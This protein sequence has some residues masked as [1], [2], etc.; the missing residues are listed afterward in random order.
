MKHTCGPTILI[1]R[2]SCCCR[3]RDYGAEAR[4]DGA[5]CCVC[6]GHCVVSISC[7]LLNDDPLTRCAC[8][9][10]RCCGHASTGTDF[11][12]VQITSCFVDAQAVLQMGWKDSGQTVANEVAGIADGVDLSGVAFDWG[13]CVCL[14]LMI[15]DSVEVAVRLHLPTAHTR[16]EPEG[17]SEDLCHLPLKGSPNVNTDCTLS[18]YVELPTAC[19]TVSICTPRFLSNKTCIMSHS[20][21][22]TIAAHKKS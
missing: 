2:L 21:T 20:S 18:A 4:E 7:R 14:A 19:V 22:L 8:A 5:G 13:A 3:S 15:Q 17:E 16:S 12:A 6:F 11:H 9:S 1:S 10:A